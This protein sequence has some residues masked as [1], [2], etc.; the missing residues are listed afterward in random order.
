MRV[1]RFRLS[2]LTHVR[3]KN[4]AA[5]YS[6]ETEDGNQGNTPVLNLGGKLLRMKVKGVFNGYVIALWE[7]AKTVNTLYGAHG[8][9]IES[10]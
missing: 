8:R 3:R 7:W 4:D 6:R 10:R 5:G 9:E 2:I 1:V